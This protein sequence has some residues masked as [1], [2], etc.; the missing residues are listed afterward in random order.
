ME[1][2]HFQLRHRLFLAHL[3]WLSNYLSYHYT[4]LYFSNRIRKR[5]LPI[6]IKTGTFKTT[7]RSVYIVKGSQH[8]SNEHTSLLFHIQQGDISQTKGRKSIVV[9]RFLKF[10]FIITKMWHI[11]GKCARFDEGKSRWYS[12]IGRDS[13]FNIISLSLS[14]YT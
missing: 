6:F 14:F 5:D 12:M 2:E 3:L 10:P 4:P 11:R 9:Y 13:L 8:L 7:P 1:F